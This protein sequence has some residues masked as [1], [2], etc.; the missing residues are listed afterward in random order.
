MLDREAHVPQELN[1]P[2]VDEEI[3]PRVDHPSDGV[4]NILV[5]AILD[6]DVRIPIGSRRAGVRSAC[7]IRQWA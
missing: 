3:G 2:E 5:Y 6:L 7:R 4:E 1:G